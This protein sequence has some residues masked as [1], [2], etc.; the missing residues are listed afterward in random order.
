MPGVSASQEAIG[1]VRAGTSISPADTAFLEKL[2]DVKVKT[3]TWILGEHLG[4]GR[5][6]AR[7]LVGKPWKQVKKK[8]HGSRD[9]LSPAQSCCVRLGGE[10]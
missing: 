9:H 8:A 3:G 5:H 6:Q 4:E 10:S 7:A 2:E 1:S